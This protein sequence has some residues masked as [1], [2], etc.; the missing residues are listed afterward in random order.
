SACDKSNSLPS[1][2]FEGIRN[3][4]TVKT[5]KSPCELQYVRQA[6]SWS[7]L[8]MH[9]AI[10]AVTEGATDNDVAAA[11]YHAVIRAGSEYMCYAPIVTSGR[12]SGVPHSTHQRVPLERVR[13]HPDRNRRVLLALQC[14]NHADG[15]GGDACQRGRAAGGNRCGKCR[16]SH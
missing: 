9:A 1:Y 4:M 6:A 15:I 8:G 2:T 11:A 10:D 14:A 7:T 16:N 5:V 3:T 12:R 13:S